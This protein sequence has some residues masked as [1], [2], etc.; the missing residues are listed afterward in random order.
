L[1]TL[2]VLS[3]GIYLWHPAIASLVLGLEGIAR[4]DG[5]NAHLITGMGFF[6]YVGMTIGMAALTYCTVERPFLALK[7]RAYP[8]SVAARNGS[9]RLKLLA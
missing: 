2:G 6:L 3:Y 8:P 4:I 7:K 1:R 5:L 9:Q